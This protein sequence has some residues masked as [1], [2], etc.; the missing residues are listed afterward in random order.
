MNLASLTSLFSFRSSDHENLI[1]LLR[2]TSDTDCGVSSI[3][4]GS[5]RDVTQ[6]SFDIQNP[7]TSLLA[8]QLRQQ[9]SVRKV[10][11]FLFQGRQMFSSMH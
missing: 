9:I 10:S 11:F 1:E 4:H 8:G 6:P 7:L 2:W 5:A 3:L